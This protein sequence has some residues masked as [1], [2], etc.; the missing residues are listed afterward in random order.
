V[1][2]ARDRAPRGGI[3]NSRAHTGVTEQ[4]PSKLPNTTSRLIAIAVSLVG[5]PGKVME[6]MHCSE[7]DFESYCA[8]LKEPEWPE[9]DR[10]I[11]LVV[12]EHNSASIVI[13]RTS[14]G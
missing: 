5:D 14:E 3:Q 8:G 12:R 7:A 9:L 13:L 2:Q 10:L 6:Q 11:A 1:L 4:A